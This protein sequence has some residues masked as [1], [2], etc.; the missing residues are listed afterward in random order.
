MRTT[1]GMPDTRVSAVAPQKVAKTA[2]VRNRTRRRIYEAVRAIEVSIKQGVYA[3][4][5]AKSGAIDASHDEISKDIEN[6]F[7]KAGLLR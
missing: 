3:A 2:V 7:V 4:I 6:L 5:F 1:T